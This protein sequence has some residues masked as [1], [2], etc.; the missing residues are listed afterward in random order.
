MLE[1]VSNV[2]VS[3]GGSVND[4]RSFV[5]SGVGVMGIVLDIPNSGSPED[6]EADLA[7]VRNPSCHPHPLPQ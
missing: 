7:R 6:L 5:M 3:N 2:V 1:K 4:S